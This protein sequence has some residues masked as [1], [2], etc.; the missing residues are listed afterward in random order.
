MA[1]HPMM[2]CH[3]YLAL[4]DYL[5]EIRSD[6]LLTAEEEHQLATAIAAGDREA[7]TRL[8]RA[9]L[10]LVVTIAR[11]Y[12]GR[13]LSMEDLIGEGNLGLIR[14][15]EEYDPRYGTR[16]STYA[17]YWIKQAIRSAL[18]NTAATIRLPAHMV[19]LLS[20]WRQMERALSRSLGYA[21]GHDQIAA[22]LE[23]SPAQSVMVQQALRAS[24][25]AAEGIEGSDDGCWAGIEAFD[26]SD[27]PENMLEAKEDHLELARRLDRLDE[28]ERKVLVL[29]YGLEGETPHT[30]KE[31]GRRLGVT[32]EWVRKI[33]LRAVAKLENQPVPSKNSAPRLPE[34]RA[35]ARR[36]RPNPRVR[37]LQSA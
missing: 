29:R 32:R 26:P 10:R 27:S 7:R 37:Q 25:L 24:H 23:L 20:R 33:E 21:P 14:A 6:E 9:N 16:F 30:L 12:A 15:A 19:G 1:R 31:V 17:A 36:S 18:T 11:D 2:D 13:G 28:R 3:L 22:A 35:T 4:N 5:Q 8:I 34:P